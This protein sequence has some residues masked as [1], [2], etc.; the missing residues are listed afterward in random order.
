MSVLSL[1][2]LHFSGNC[3]WNP[4][5]PNNS[6]GV[7]DE[8]TLQQNPAQSTDPAQF[9]QWLTSLNPN[10]PAGQAGL[11][12]SWNVY[13]DGGCW[14][15]NTRVT[16]VQ[17]EYGKTAGDPICTDPTAQLQIVGEFF[18]PSRPGSTPPPARMVDVAP[19]QSTTTQLFYKWFQLGTDAL[20]FRALGASRMFLRW[21][22]L[23]NTD[24]H[25]L[26][27]AGPAG[28]IFQTAARA[29]DIEWYG[30]DNSPAL[31]ALQAAANAG[32]NQGVV[33]QFAVYLTQYYLHAS[34]QGVQLS[35]AALLSQAYANGFTGANP[36][37]SNITGTIGVWGPNELASAPTQMLLNPANPVSAAT[38]PMHSSRAA[39]EGL[40]VAA[41]K[42][43]AA[44]PLGP[45]M[46]RVDAD[47]NNLAV[48]FLTTVLETDLKL[49]KEHLGPLTLQLVDGSS[50]ATTN[51]ADIPYS[52]PDNTGYDAPSYA[53]TSGILDFTIT[54]EQA[55]A[56]QNGS[57]LLQ[58][59]VEQSGTC[60]VALQQASLVAETDQRGIYLD[61]GET[62]TVTVQVY[63]NGVP[64]SGGN[65]SLLVAQYYEAPLDPSNDFPYYLVTQSNQ[66][67]ACLQLDGG[68]FQV[69]LPVTDG[70]ASFTI[71]SV[72]PGTA[73]L[74]FFPFSGDTPPAPAPGGVNNF[75][76]PQTTN[77]YAVVRCLGFDNALLDLPDDQINWENTYEKVLQVYNLV[78]P[79]MSRIADLGDPTTVEQMAGR[80]LKATEYPDR[81]DW[82]MFMPVTREMSAGKRSLLRRFC[83]NA[84]GGKTAPGTKDG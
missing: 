56:I 65:V 18:G 63:Q 60:T 59:S 54:P 22:M 34:Y 8:N 42:A 10:P 36:A 74:G 3:L 27:I 84:L 68:Q 19:Y 82:T 47:A 44:F 78:Y 75:P 20:G 33:M 73:M 39:Q 58:L 48:S 76:G 62:Q 38:V 7:Y 30:L 1:P 45:A 13:G 80:I 69:V 29:Q 67:N 81:F 35:N 49:T 4:N 79:Q 16:G 25:E 55:T 5:T 77:F 31:R 26:Q 11:N 61:Q 70:T 2:R 9:V 66:N 37:Q 50:G 51:I 41:P 71:T 23:R 53:Q 14:F 6:P 28:V 83:Q 57:S 32:P 24:F 72:N 12:G 17:F 52:S 40:V 43:P 64:A 15:S 46:A 21:S